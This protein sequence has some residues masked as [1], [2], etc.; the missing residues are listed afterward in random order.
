MKVSDLM[1]M[2]VAMLTAEDA[3]LAVA[4]L[5]KY[6]PETDLKDADLEVEV[7][8]L[9]CDVMERRQESFGIKAVNRLISILEQHK[10]TLPEDLVA[11]AETV[12]AQLGR[13]ALSD[14][15]VRGLF[16]ALAGA[17]RRP[18]KEDTE[19]DIRD[20]LDCDSCTKD[21]PNAGGHM[22][23]GGGDREK[24]RWN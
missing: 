12:I 8:K 20:I 17:A 15:L 18:Q 13:R 24:E 19:T 10:P 22:T 4:L 16:G 23:E 7:L 11:A 2:A 6:K 21:C 14:E 1:G 9:V 5:D 3:A